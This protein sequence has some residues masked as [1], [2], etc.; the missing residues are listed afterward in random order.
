RRGD[1]AYILGYPKALVRAQTKGIV[2]EPGFKA[3]DGSR[4]DA[5]DVTGTFGNSGSPYFIRRG[6]TLYWAGTVGAL[7]PHRESHTSLFMLGIP[8]RQYK[9]LLTPVG[10][11]AKT[12]AGNTP[13]DAGK[14]KR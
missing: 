6:K 10:T 11:D 12:K 14:P 8:I 1:E 3:S 4:Y 7:I 9:D 13:G 5:L 2:A